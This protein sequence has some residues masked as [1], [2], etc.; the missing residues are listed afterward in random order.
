M[1]TPAPSRLDKLFSSASF[2]VYMI[3]ACLRSPAETCRVT[4]RIMASTPFVVSPDKWQF[5]GWI[6]HLFHLRQTCTDTDSVALRLVSV[7]DWETACT[8][9]TVSLTWLEA[10]KQQKTKKH[11]LFFCFFAGRWNAGH[12]STCVS[13][14]YLR[15]L[16]GQEKCGLCV[17]VCVLESLNPPVRLY[18]ILLSTYVSG[19]N[20]FKGMK[21][22][23]ACK[24]AHCCPEEFGLPIIDAH[25]HS[26]PS[27]RGP[28]AQ[29]RSL[30]HTLSCG[31][32]SVLC[33][34]F[35]PENTLH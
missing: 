11:N 7:I 29:P 20:M 5:K 14:K 31:S 35:S 24:S 4:G 30:F 2:Y 26:S 16:M 21:N 32:S 28:N 9:C 3:C 17:C 22:V 15:N 33:H 34:S 18:F 12:A 6:S 27:C 1:Y 25:F 19:G 10:C 13:P 8:G 23:K